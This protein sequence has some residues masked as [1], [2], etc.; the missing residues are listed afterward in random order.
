[1]ADYVLRLH[2]VTGGPGTLVAVSDGV[3]KVGKVTAA[4]DE[5]C[6]SQAHVLSSARGAY[7]A[8]S[9]SRI[10]FLGSTFNCLLW[11]VACA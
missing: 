2:T 4:P 3:V 8:E 1:M 6:T 11:G 9:G 5:S 10:F 7:H